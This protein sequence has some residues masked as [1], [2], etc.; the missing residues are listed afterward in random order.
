MK[1][2]AAGAVTL[3][4]GGWAVTATAQVVILSRWE[5]PAVRART[6]APTQDVYQLAAAG[7]WDSSAPREWSAYRLRIGLPDGQTLVQ[8][9]EANTGPTA[10]R[11]LARIPA[12]AVLNRRPDT[13][14]VTLAVTDLSG[15][16]VSNE[17]TADIGDFPRPGV[18]PGSPRRASVANEP[19]SRGTPLADDGAPALPGPGP[20]G[21]RFVRLPVATGAPAVFLATSEASNAQ[22][23]LRLKD[24]TPQKN[25]SDEF[26]L[27]APDQPAFGLTPD[28]ARAYLAALTAETGVGAT[29]RLPLRSEWLNAA[30]A[31]Q[32]TAFWWGDEATFP[33][34]AN[35]L[36]AEPA[37][38]TD[39]TAVTVPGTA[40][41]TFQAN[42]WGLAHT[43]GN[44]AEWADEPGTGVFRMGGHFRTE[45]V[46][47]MT[48]PMV[49]SGA[50]TGDDLFVGVRPAFTMD[51]EAGKK[52]IE[53]ALAGAP[54]L[55]GVTASFDPARATATLTGAVAE[56]ELRALALQKLAGLWWLAAV[57]N[58]VAAPI[59][60]KGQLALLEAI[61]NAPV[62]TE[63]V[64][65]IDFDVAPVQARWADALPVE[66]S[67]WFV[68]VFGP[69]GPF[70]YPLDLKLVG[71]KGPIDVYMNPSLVPPGSTVAV[72]LTVGGPAT[73]PADP[74]LVSNAAVVARPSKP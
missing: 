22:V 33:A 70:S 38:S 62:R 56:P 11:V 34:G 12:T 15:N 24:Y 69:G 35:F 50:E 18:I 2:A 55:S 25:R 51:A 41:P 53:E 59:V 72:S 61:P 60:A 20:D 6:Y 30:R 13:V 28:R 49:N 73:G 65:S 71:R 31:G 54:E 64:G 63:R 43:F 47:P 9:L 66:G 7:A 57:D 8:N 27:D 36:G 14:H 16:L 19:I 29:F 21:L 45:P 3:L 74:A 44:V 4:M 58:Q 17:L 67:T 48:D 68:N 5:G 32:S 40:A 23:A 52:A 37:L 1:L 42:G 46:T 10:G 39:T 26:V